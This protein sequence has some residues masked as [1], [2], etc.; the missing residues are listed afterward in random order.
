M[1]YYVLTS[2]DTSINQSLE[3]KVAEG[4]VPTMLSSTKASGTGSTYISVML[5]RE[6]EYVETG[7]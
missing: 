2:V 1:E 5:E 6:R 4:W 7:E 3:K